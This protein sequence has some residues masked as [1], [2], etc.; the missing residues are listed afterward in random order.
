[1]R[2]N[3]SAAVAATV[4]AALAAAAPASAQSVTTTARAESLGHPLSSTQSTMSVQC[5]AVAAVGVGTYIDRCYLRG[6]FS[7]LRYD[8]PST[9]AKPGPTDARA[10]AVVVDYEPFEVCVGARAVLSDGSFYST[11]LNCFSN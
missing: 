5:A 8:M 6:L 9:G 11:P 10:G 1:M 4:V 3:K 7:G 2:F